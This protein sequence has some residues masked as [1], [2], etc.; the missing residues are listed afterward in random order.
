MQT[1]VSAAALLAW[2]RAAGEPTRLRLLALCT[3]REL[4]VSELALAVGQSEPRVSRHLK[5]LCAAGLVARLRCGQWVHYRLAQ[6][7]RAAR[8][9]QALVADLDP[10]DP[11]F[12]PERGHVRAAG[13]Q[14]PHDPDARARLGEAIASFM[15]ASSAHLSGPNALIVGVRHHAM[16]AHAVR[17][18]SAATAIA[19]S[20]RAAQAA[21]AFLKRE[22]LS[23]RVVYAQPADA[24]IPPALLRCGPRYEAIVLDRLAAPAAPL[25]LWLSCARQVLAATGRL[26]LFEREDALSGPELSAPGRPVARLRRLLDEAGFA[27][28]RV[29]PVSAGRAAILAAVAVPDWAVR[30]ASVA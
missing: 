23:C 26:W 17:T 6:D 25:A 9:L 10:A 3:Q 14:R 21:S 20:R 30:A 1:E 5:I 16:L 13:T 4:S 12:A 15:A 2:L 28:E 24:P 29:S 19:H 7:P 27:C 18:C 11:V 8:F 22:R